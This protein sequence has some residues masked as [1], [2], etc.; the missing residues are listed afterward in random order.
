M[1][2]DGRIATAY[3]A[4]V[5]SHPEDVVDLEPSQPVNRASAVTVASRLSQ[6]CGGVFRV[7]PG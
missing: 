2:A 3:T 7:F 5:N 1:T 6:L 4:A